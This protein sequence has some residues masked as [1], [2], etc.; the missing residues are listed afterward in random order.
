MQ[1][2]EQERNRKFQK[3]EMIKVDLFQSFASDFPCDEIAPSC[4]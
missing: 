3:E 4:R 2:K 1:L